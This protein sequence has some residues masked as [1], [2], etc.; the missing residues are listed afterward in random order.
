MNHLDAWLGDAAAR[1]VALLGRAPAAAAVACIVA[2]AAAISLALPHLGLNSDEDAL[3]SP[4]TAYAELRSDFAAAFP[5]TLDPVI[6]LIDGGDAER[7][8]AVAERLATRLAEEP[9]HFPA[10]YDPEARSFFQDQG[11]LYLD[12]SALG[13]TVDRLIEAQPLLAAFARDP[14]LRGLSQVLGGALGA[15][16]AQRFDPWLREIARTIAS[17]NDG[18]PRPPDWSELF[19]AA[20]APVNPRRYLLVQ[21]VVDHARLEP[22]AETLVALDDVLAELGLSSDA[23]PVRVRVTGLYPLS[24][25]EAHLVERQVRLAGVASFILVAAVLWVGIR[26]VRHVFY[27]MLTLCAG[28]AACA[29]FAGFAIGHLNLVSVAFGVLFIGL[30]IDF[31]IHWLLRYREL[32]R[33]GR[34]RDEALGETARSVG[35]SLMMCAVTTAIGFFAFVPSDFVGVAELGLIAGVGMFISLFTN[36]T[37]LPALL[38]LGPE[39][40]V[41]RAAPRTAPKSAPGFS[42]RHRVAVVTGATLLGAAAC[43]LLPRVHFDLNPLR[44]RDPGAESVR[45]FDALLAEGR[46]F[47]WNLNVLAPSDA[48]A[49]ALRDR[50]E[51]LPTVAATVTVDDWIPSDQPEKLALLEDAALVLAPALDP[52][53]REAPPSDAE[54]LAA[55]GDLGARAG[56]TQ[57]EASPAT[58]ELADSLT[59]FVAG[60][61]VAPE[62]ALRSLREVLVDSLAEELARLRTLLGSAA[63]SRETLPPSIVSQRVARDGRIRIEVFP[64][65]DLSDNDALARFVADVRSVDPNTFGEGVV[66]YESGRIV[67]RAFRRAL[68]LAAAGAPD[69][70]GRGFARGRDGPVRRSAQLRQRDRHPPAARDGGRYRHSPGASLSLRRGS[71][72]P[73]GHQYRTGGRVL[74]AHDVGELRDAGVYLSPRDGELGSAAR[75]WPRA[76]RGVQPAGASQPGPGLGETGRLGRF[77]EARDPL[78]PGAIFGRRRFASEAARQQ[79]Q[80]VDPELGVLCHRVR[81]DLAGRRGDGELQG[82]ERG[83]ALEALRGVAQP[84]DAAPRRLHV[85]GKSVPTVA[86][87]DRAAQRPGAPPPDHD[88]RRLLHRPRKRVDPRERDKSPA[89]TRLGLQPQ[90]PNRVDRLVGARALVGERN[91][92]RVELGFQVTHAD[93]ENQPAA[94][95]DVDAR[96]LLG[97]LDR[98]ALGHDDDPRREPDALG[99][100]REERERGRRIEHGV[101]G[102][103]RRRRHV[104]IGEDDV[105]TGPQRFDTRRLGAACDLE[106][107]IGSAQRPVVDAKN[108]DLHGGLQRTGMGWGVA[109]RKAPPPE[110]ARGSSQPL[111]PLRRHFL[112]L[113]HDGAR[114]EPQ[115]SLAFLVRHPAEAEHT[116]ERVGADAL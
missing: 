47:P 69:R 73:P 109:T 86:P 39:P 3:F 53:T 99:G 25:E 83:R 62:P 12:P 28:L 40:E 61:E 35:G 91:P 14:S 31:G 34:T 77:A 98:V 10:V 59:R 92:E 52:P 104:G 20:P 96:Q 56:Q 112:E 72:G 105:L 82:S 17:V 75:H 111:P 51:A 26:S 41:Q 106:H 93:P 95:E 110:G 80:A 103:N 102:R 55:L 57:G 46:A 19:G 64:A 108:S 22:A 29:A 101:F 94:G 45:A 58:R 13:D 23:G 85:E 43:L 67:V 79:H 66:I 54:A 89:E 116:E 2:A 97:E 84:Q 87:L 63:I 71:S 107:Q 81:V 32:V 88:R 6:L 30:S 65:E 38:R 18:Q 42:E 37:L 48:A 7:V 49:H 21:P 4:N 16:G 44:V 68:A 60:A 11:L 27:A 1:W 100:S 50:L 33:G 15:P 9:E 78:D 74:R 70:L 5:H 36:L 115:V 76:D 113:R 8:D 24:Y 114:K 90:R